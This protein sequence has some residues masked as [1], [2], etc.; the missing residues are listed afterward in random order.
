MDADVGGVTEGD[1]FS[2]VFVEELSA[3]GKR[4]GM[5]NTLNAGKRKCFTQNALIEKP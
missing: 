5:E 2:V 3:V 4:R 1:I